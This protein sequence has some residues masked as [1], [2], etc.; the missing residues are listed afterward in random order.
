MSSKNKQVLQTSSEDWKTY[1]YSHGN[2]KIEFRLRRD[3]KDHL[4]SAKI[5]FDKVVRDI[6]DDIDYQ[7]SKKTK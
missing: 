4:A 2:V 3:I 5:I 6:Q 7:D 1:Q